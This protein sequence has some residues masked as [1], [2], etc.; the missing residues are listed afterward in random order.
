MGAPNG[1]ICSLSKSST[2]KSSNSLEF[3]SFII[4]FLLSSF[5]FNSSFDEDKDFS[6]FFH[7]SKILASLGNIE[8]CFSRTSLMLLLYKEEDI[9]S[10]STTIIFSLC[11]SKNLLLTYLSKKCSFLASPNSI[12]SHVNFTGTLSFVLKG[13]LYS[14]RIFTIIRAC[15]SAL[16]ISLLKGKINP[17]LNLE[18]LYFV[19]FVFFFLLIRSSFFIL[20]YSSP[21]IYSKSS[22]NS[23]INSWRAVF[24]VNFLSELFPSSFVG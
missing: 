23:L 20:S 13:E 7:L 8:S 9:E 4:L 3:V 10:S 18:F 15:S 11:F 24:L 1:F 6:K 14:G 22:L 17:L 19:L 5:L 12:H 16:D 21:L 2:T